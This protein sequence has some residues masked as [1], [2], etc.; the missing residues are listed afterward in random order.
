MSKKDSNALDVKASCSKN[1]MDSVPALEVALICR[2]DA[3]RTTGLLFLD[4]EKVIAAGSHQPL[5]G[6]ISIVDIRGNLLFWAYIQ[7]DEVCKYNTKMTGLNA[8][9]LRSGVRIE[10]IRKLLDRLFRGKTIYGADIRNNWISLGYTE[11]RPESGASK[12][13]QEFYR[14]AKNQPI[15]LGVLSEHFL[16]QDMQEKIHSSIVDARV[17]AVCYRRIIK[18]KSDEKERYDCE[19]FHDLRDSIGKPKRQANWDRKCTCGAT[20]TKMKNKKKGKVEYSGFG[21]V[22]LEH[23]NWD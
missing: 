13:I 5:A 3:L 1:V 14:D 15:G 21:N 2:G 17:T 16:G 23:W 11:G 19:V 7:R 18:M 6:D 22:S 12:D 8:D 9:K 20:K 10:F 4:V